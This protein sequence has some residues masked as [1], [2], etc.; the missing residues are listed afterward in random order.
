MCRSTPAVP[1]TYLLTSAERQLHFSWLQAPSA[2]AASVYALAH[3]AGCR[4]SCE[5]Y[6]KFPPSHAVATRLSY[7]QHHWCLTTLKLV[8]RSLR[9]IRAAD[10]GGPGAA[11]LCFGE[12]PRLVFPAASSTRHIPSAVQ[13]TSTA[14]QPT[15]STWQA[16]RLR[17][18]QV[19]TH[20]LPTQDQVDVLASLLALHA[21][22][23]CLSYASY[24]RVSSCGGARSVSCPVHTAQ[25]ACRPGD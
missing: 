10:G 14:Q 24:R 5:S 17:H 18:L 16:A 12:Q 6:S 20:D 1:V 7:S 3:E 9:P 15:S 8:R 11:G 21:R 23:G 2:I 13:Q 4:E 25:H 22:G 19:L